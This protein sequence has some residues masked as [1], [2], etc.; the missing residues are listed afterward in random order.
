MGYSPTY[1]IKGGSIML[2]YNLLSPIRVWLRKCIIAII[3]LYITKIP[4]LLHVV[5]IIGYITAYNYFKE[6]VYNRYFERCI[7]DTIRKFPENTRESSIEI[8][9]KLFV[10]PLKE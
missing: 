1:E 5:L 7:A 8:C 10:N 9:D 3:K 4:M 2:I 6:P